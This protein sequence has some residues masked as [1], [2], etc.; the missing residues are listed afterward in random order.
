M[1]DTIYTALASPA[2]D[3]PTLILIFTLKHR[4]GSI[5]FRNG[6]ISRD[7]HGTTHCDGFEVGL[8]C[9]S[10][11]EHYKGTAA[12]FKNFVCERNQ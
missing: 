3:E 1:A 2:N 9:F 4:A 11:E 7:T 10:H 8:F 5:K 6:Y 12:R